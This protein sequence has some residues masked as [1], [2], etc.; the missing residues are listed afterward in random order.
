MY[1]TLVRTLDH[2]ES[3]ES[4]KTENPSN[5]PIESLCEVKLHKWN[6]EHQLKLGSITYIVG[7]SC[8]GKSI[9]FRSLYS[10]IA[11]QIDELFV[12]AALEH[13]YK[14]LTIDSHIYENSNKLEALF[15]YFRKNPKIK[16]VLIF[17]RSEFDFKSPAIRSIFVNGRHL[18]LTVFI[19]ADYPL[20]MPPFLRAQVDNCFFAREERMSIQKTIY[21]RHGSFIPTFKNFCALWNLATTPCYQF[22]VL[23]QNSCYWIKSE[24]IDETKIEKKIV[25]AN[26]EPSQNT[27]KMQQLRVQVKQLKSLCSQILDGMDDVSPPPPP[28]PQLTPFGESLS[29]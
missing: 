12:F 26:I 18:N 14:N 11:D 8:S 1:Q 7:R 17:D 22:F 3:D 6:P 10:L 16:R 28:N 2:Y 13:K 25:E 23:S 19:I 5:Q 27:L 29:E 4:S 9:L 24:L 20:H 15:S 21:D